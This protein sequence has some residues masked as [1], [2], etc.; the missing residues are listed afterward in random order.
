MRRWHGLIALL[1]VALTAGFLYKLTFTD[2]ILGRGD[3][4]AY[5]YPYWD[6]RDAALLDGRLP[7]WSPD[8]FMGVPLLA[9]SQIGTFYPPNWLTIPLA[10]PDAVRVSILLHTLWAALGAFWLARVT[11]RVPVLAALVGGVVFAFG[12]YFGAQ[13]EQINQ[14]QGLAWMPFLFLTLHVAYKRPA[15]YLPLLGLMW[16]LQ[17]LTG[18]TQTAF[19]SGVGLGL[20]ALCLPYLHDEGGQT[21]LHSA[22]ALIKPLALVAVAAFGAVVIALPQLAPTQELIAVSNRGDGL[23]RQEATA[24]SLDPAI[25]GRGLLPSAAGQPFS[26]YVAYLGVVGLGLAVIGVIAGAGRARLAW[27]LIAGAGF[28]L[29]L[30]RHNPLYYELLAGAPG[31][32]LFRVPARWLALFALGGALLAALGTAALMARRVRPLPILAIHGFLIAVLAGASFL[33]ESGAERITEPAQ[34]TLPTLALWAGA[35]IAFGVLM[36]S[37]RARAISA[38]I[39]FAV[40]AELW[41]ASA[42]LPYNDLVDPAVYREP[43]FPIQQLRAFAEESAEQSSAPQRFLSI[44]RQAFDLGDEATLRERWSARGMGRVAVDHAFTAVKLNE[45]AAPNLPLTWG[46]PT[47]DGF[48]GGVLPTIYYSAFAELLTPPDAPRTTDGRLREYLALPDCRGACIPPRRWL[49]LSGVRYLLLDKVYDVVESGVFFDTAFST[50]LDAGD[51]TFRNYDGFAA[52]ELHLLYICTNENVCSLPA[53]YFDDVA[54]SPAESARS[55]ESFQ[56]MQYTASDFTAPDVVRL[57]AADGGVVVV[58]VTLVDARTGDFWQMTPDGWRRIYSAE[59]KLYENQTALPRARVVDAGWYVADSMWAGTARALNIMRS[60]RYDP[61]VHTVIHQPYMADAEDAAPFNMRAVGG[62]AQVVAYDDTR[63]EIA[64]RARQERSYLVLTDSFYPGWSVTV[65][66]ESAEVLRA[67]VAF[68]AVA[69]PAGDSVVVFTYD[70]DYLWWL[71]LI[72][73][74]VFPA[75]ILFVFFVLFSVER[76]TKK[77]F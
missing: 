32:N 42:T 47:V 56:L 33:A 51:A 10:A 52:D 36:W 46:I 63:V 20:Y 65:N 6:A 43:R 38:V 37:A 77:D 62:R 69:I 55:V 67:D 7:L 17:L 39:V 64:V 15:R 21:M 14:L 45:V 61:A 53:A 30:G 49:D 44:S 27:G 19:I 68:R 34:P 1:L 4:F 54:L 13:S 11:L 26:E 66:G 9:N 23:N 48:D 5:F 25:I 76:R 41:L 60:S 31:F 18:H 8:L 16:G 24:F 74:G 75:V 71:M 57:S 59:V 73:W 70:I 2:L 58:A 22:R 28:F 50:P 72:A 12:G 29:A 35:F 3:T 40:V